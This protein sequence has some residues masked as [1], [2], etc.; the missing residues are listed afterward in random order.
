[1][2]LSRH[3]K[4]FA[5]DFGEM[6]RTPVLA[7]SVVLS[8]LFCV[9]NVWLPIW[10]IVPLSNDRPFIPLHYNIYLGVDRFGDWKEIFLLPT[11]GLGLFL[12]NLVLQTL[13]VRRERFLSM[14]FGV[15][16]VFLEAIL[17]FALALIILLNLSYAA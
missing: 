4:R 1:M 8:F 5:E 6:I 15:T 12:L 14:M 3:L 17:F 16:T 13:A 11:L 10:R 9:M 7:W 2:K